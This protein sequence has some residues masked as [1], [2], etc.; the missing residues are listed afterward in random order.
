MLVISR[1]IGQGLVIK[2]PTGELIKIK[3][4]RENVMGQI[5]VVIDAPRTILILRDEAFNKKSQDGS[6]PWEDKP[7]YNL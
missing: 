6:Y 3:L 1:N 4:D 5:P 7:N 2:C